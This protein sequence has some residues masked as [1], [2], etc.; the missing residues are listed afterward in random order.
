MIDTQKLRQRILDLAIRGKLVPQD[1]NDEPASELLERIRAEKERLIA[2]GK[3]KRPKAKKVTTDTPHYVPFE[4]PTSWQWVRLGDIGDWQAGATPSRSNKKYYGGNIPWLKTGELNDGIIDIVSEY[5]TEDALKETSVKLNPIGSVLIA[6]YGATIGKVGILNIEATTNQACCACK[7]YF[8]DRD[9]LFYFLL[10]NRHKFIELRGGGA[11]PNISKEIITSFPF[12]CPPFK[13][14]ERIVATIKNF[15][16]IL[17]V[18]A[19]E[20]D[21]LVNLTDSAK[22]KILEL[23]V[24]GKLV[25]QNPDDEP[26][27]ELLK[28]INPRAEIIT[29]NGH[30]PQL[31]SGW[32]VCHISDVCNYGQTKQ[33]AV[34]EI[35]DNEWVLE[36]E[37][38][39]K[40]SGKVIDRKSK[41]D[42]SINGI[43]NKFEPE[44]V[45]YSKL[46][47]YLNKVMVADDNGYCSTEIV[48]IQCSNAIIPQYLCSFMRSPQFLSYTAQYGY[49]VKMP[50]LSTT[51]AKRGIILLPPLEEQHRIIAQID[52]I[53]KELDFI[54]SSLQSNLSTS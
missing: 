48:P 2:E 37:D 5:I 6:M 28:R 10:A 14:Q 15:E 54:T 1:P 49:G 40:D 16:D 53:S 24:S 31:P 29:D 21:N 35:E 30:Y 3:I 20:K 18:I 41:A 8:V 33:V 7:N 11:Q 47:T 26:A 51:D 46:R 45:L 36:L 32:C 25:S 27:S 12:P 34:E 4:I 50:R 9:F 19:T 23:A 13:E 42:R 17:K 38:I 52:R 22:S 39:E 44:M 43:R